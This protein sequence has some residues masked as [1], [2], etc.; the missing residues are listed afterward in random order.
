[1]SK[2]TLPLKMQP[3]F[4]KAVIWL[5]AS[6]N[7]LHYDFTGNISIIFALAIIAPVLWAVTISKALSATVRILDQWSQK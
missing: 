7:A 4:Y 6:A 5:W 1:M 3:H 2:R